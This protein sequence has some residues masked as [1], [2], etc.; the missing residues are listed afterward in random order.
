MAFTPRI[1]P[2]TGADCCTRVNAD[3]SKAYAR[4]PCEPC[5][6]HHRAAGR[7]AA[8][9]RTATDFVP[10]DPYAAGIAVLR[11]SHA[12]AAAERTPAPLP[13]EMHLD[14]HGIPDP[15]FH[16]LEKLRSA[17]R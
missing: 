17:N 14:Q 9:L 13:T 16:D 1:D 5:R 11:A 8:A 3:G 2:T 7:R 10:P 6:E 12:K 4:N 15:Y